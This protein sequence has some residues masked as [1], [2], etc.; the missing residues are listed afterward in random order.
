MSTFVAGELESEV[1]VLMRRKRD[2]DMV[3][4]LG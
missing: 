1:E 3:S 4:G 2:E